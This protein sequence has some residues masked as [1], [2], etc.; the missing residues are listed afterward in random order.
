MAA[1]Q[2][3][4]P[5]G[6]VMYRRLLSPLCD[7]IVEHAMPR[8]VR[9]N[10]LTSMSLLCVTGNFLMVRDHARGDLLQ[11]SDAQCYGIAGAVH[12]LYCLLD[13]TD[14]KQARRTRRSSAAGEYL[15]HA[16]DSLAASLT[17]MYAGYSLVPRDADGAGARFLEALTPRA[18][19]VWHV[20][21]LLLHWHHQLSGC[22]LLGV[23][24]WLT[25]DEINFILVPSLCWLR[26]GGLLDALHRSVP[27]YQLSCLAACAGMALADTKI[28]KLG[29]AA[30]RAQSPRDARLLRPL[31][32]LALHCPLALAQSSGF[33]SSLAFSITCSA[34]LVAQR[35][36]VPMWLWASGVLLLLPPLL[37]DE[38]W[39]G[40]L[41]AVYLLLFVLQLRVTA[42]RLIA[43]SAR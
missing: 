41:E 42:D 3:N 36:A 40:W 21:T 37:L 10:A 2:Y 6:S 9:P 33:V 30:M 20:G 31:A 28:F 38:A 5:T 43:R 14:G 35:L 8:W 18:V 11:L 13:N 27:L 7:A 4:L 34:Y 39:T 25:V 16:V 17:A 19:V 12:M 26:A 23:S 22:L 15:D 1:Y 29:L 32:V 24:K